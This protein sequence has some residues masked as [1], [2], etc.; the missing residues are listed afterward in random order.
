MLLKH[1]N[2]WRMQ[3][4]ELIFLQKALEIL[5]TLLVVMKVS[6]IHLYIYVFVVFQLKYSYFLLTRIFEPNKKVVTGGCRKVNIEGFN[7]LCSS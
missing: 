7:K 2:C 5:F 3:S 4:K 6:S 1:H